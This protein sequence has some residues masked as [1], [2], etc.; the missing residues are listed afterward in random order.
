M[1]EGGYVLFLVF[2]GDNTVPVYKKEF[3]PLHN[4]CLALLSKLLK[5]GCCGYWDNLYP[6]VDVAQEVAR[7]G[8]YTATVP[9]GPHAA[10]WVNREVGL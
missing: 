8:E 3:S 6:S 9:A 5:P 2:R 7:G 10:R 1:L 4:R